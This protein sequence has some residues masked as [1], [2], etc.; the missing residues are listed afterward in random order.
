MVLADYYS[1]KKSPL[2]SKMCICS[3]DLIDPDKGSCACGFFEL[4]G[5]GASRH[6]CM[7]DC[8]FPRCSRK[9]Y[10]QAYKAAATTTPSVLTSDEILRLTDKPQEENESES[11]YY[12]SDY[13]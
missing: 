3:L 6:I 12:Y 5:I 8:P 11:E 2:K 10:Y 7:P 9:Q 1:P 13:D 4:I